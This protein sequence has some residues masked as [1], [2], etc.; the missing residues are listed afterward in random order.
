MDPVLRFSPKNLHNPQG[1]KGKGGQDLLRAYAI[2]YLREEVKAEALVRNLQGFQ[3]F[4]D[5]A[6]AQYSTD[7]FDCCQGHR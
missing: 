4:L 7:A 2:T 5:I 6:V 3:N 1:E